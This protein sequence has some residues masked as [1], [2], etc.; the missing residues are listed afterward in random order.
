MVEGFVKALLAPR[1]TRVE[2]RA[3]KI[4][5]EEIRVCILWMNLF[6]LLLGRC[7]FFHGNKSILSLHVVTLI[8]KTKPM[9][10]MRV[11]LSYLLSSLPTELC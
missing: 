4:E 10:L 11:H 1:A 2:K 9:S 6:S 5:T 3:T 7:F 8:V